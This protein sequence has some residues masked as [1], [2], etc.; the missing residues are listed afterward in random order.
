MKREFIRY[1][2][3]Y[4][5]LEELLYPIYRSLEKE[6]KENKELELVDEETVE[7]YIK[8]HAEKIVKD[9]DIYVHGDTDIP[10]C[11]MDIKINW[12]KDNIMA[13]DFDDIIKDIDDYYK[14]LEKGLLHDRIQ[15]IDYETHLNIFQDY[16]FEWFFRAFG[17]Y[18]FEYNFINFVK[19]IKLCLKQ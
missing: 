13:M 7:K 18:G 16:A 2:D 17:T 3:V 12:N 6:A 11:L 14:Y 10:G 8:E 1:E 19:K 5:K 4:K 15:K 9:F